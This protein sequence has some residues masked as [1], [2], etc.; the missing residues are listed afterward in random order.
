MLVL[1]R[2][3]IRS[4]MKVVKRELKH[5]SPVTNTRDNCPV[6]R[7]SWSPQ[8]VPLPPS[9][10]AGIRGGR[11][12]LHAG[13]SIPFFVIILFT[14]LAVGTAVP[15]SPSHFSVVP[16]RRE[17]TAPDSALHSRTRT[18][19]LSLRPHFAATTATKRLQTMPSY[20]NNAGRPFPLS[21]LS[22]P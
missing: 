18:L 12:K 16:L 19:C 22:Y 6:T 21:R 7:S 14:S 4:Q 5:T 3:K 20:E 10:F 9:Q 13:P 11:S 2:C 17:M 1:V 8:Q 15:T